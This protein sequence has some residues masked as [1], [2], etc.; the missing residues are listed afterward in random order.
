MI[1][2]VSHVTK[3]YVNDGAATRALEDVSLS[4]DEGEFVAIMGPSGSGKSTLLHLLSLLDTPTS[5]IYR[6]LGKNV[7]DYSEDERAHMRNETIGFVFQ[8]FNLLGRSSV[9]DNVEMPLLYTN[10]SLEE[11]KKRVEQAVAA[12]GLAEKLHTEALFLSGGQKQRVAIARAL[13]TQPKVIFADE[14]TGNLD[15]K[16]GAQI[17]EML[18]E[19][20]R[21]GHTIILVTHEGQTAQCA[22]RLIK[23]RDGNVESDTP[24]TASQPVS[25]DYK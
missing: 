13:V 23:I 12:V 9:F 14:P 2:E 21:Q 19:L 25:V 10:L 7:S 24:I 4:I 8:S 6:L 15:S 17:M 5:G 22:R 1:I 16:S 3:D 20:N 18:T 11:R